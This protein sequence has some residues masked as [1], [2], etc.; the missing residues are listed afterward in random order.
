MG[1][2]VI[3]ALGRMGVPVVAVHYDPRDMGYTSRYVKVSL[4]APHPEQH[5]EEFLDVL[6]EAAARY[7]G[8]VLFPVSDPALRVVSKHKP[9]LSEHFAVACAGW[10]IT[11]RLIDKQQT[12]ALAGAAGVPVPRTVVPRCVEDV[13]RYGREF[14]YPCLVKPSWGH[15][16]FEIFHTKMV[17]AG[18]FDE[19]LAA[20]EQAAAAGQEVMLQELIPGDDT[21]VINYNSYFWEGEPL[22]EFTA[23]QIRKAPPMFGSPCVAVSE[24]VPGAIE[25]GRQTLRALGFY[26]YSCTEVKLDPRDGV[27]KLMEVNGRHNLSTLLAVSCG[28]NYPWLH[29]RHL[30]Y[31]EKPSQAPYRSGLY[32][33][34]L[35]RDAAHSVRNYRRQRAGFIRRF[36]EPYVKPH[37][38]AVLD[39]RDPR[40]FLTR[41]GHEIG[42]EQRAAPPGSARTKDSTALRGA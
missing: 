1:L 17:E 33:I 37:V 41:L 30:A 40:P 11:E 9:A 21:H 19:L 27:Y 12:Y 35:A 39:L 34:D 10:E 14:E 24:V 28:I 26:G 22:V 5:E 29:Y 23:R 25:I 42:G 15:Q 31:G 18:S 32:W 20:Y 3:R 16:Y 38:F 8:S 13:E 7:A 6:K 4:R 36:V 2:G